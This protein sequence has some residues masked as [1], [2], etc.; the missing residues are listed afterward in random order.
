V[1]YVT[2]GMHDRS[3]MICAL[4]ASLKDRCGMILSKMILYKLAGLFSR[5]CEGQGA[6]WVEFAHPSSKWLVVFAVQSQTTHS[7]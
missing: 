5:A 7:V 1:G 2:V 6:A 3:L 4:S